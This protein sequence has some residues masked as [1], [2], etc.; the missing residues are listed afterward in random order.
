MSQ[1]LD[2]LDDNQ[3]EIVTRVKRSLAAL[4]ADLHELGNAGLSAD[5]SSIGV[6][7]IGVPASTRIVI[8]NIGLPTQ[9][10]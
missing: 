3:K 2:L 9:R 10:I 8:I 5:I 6:D 4:N 7:T 1:L